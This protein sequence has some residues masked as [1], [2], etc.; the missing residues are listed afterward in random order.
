MDHFKYLIIGGGAAGTA[1]AESIRQKDPVGTI[2]IINEEPYMLYS[3]VMLSKPNFFL[4]QVPFDQ[5]YLKTEEWY[6]K[7]AITYI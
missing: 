6:K 7:L 2:A 1:A 5:V 4:G 3:R